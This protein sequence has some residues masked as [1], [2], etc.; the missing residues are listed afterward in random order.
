MTFE[1][2]CPS[3]LSGQLITITAHE[4]TNS[5][6]VVCYTSDEAWYSICNS[7]PHD[8]PAT[9]VHIL[10]SLKVR[11]VHLTLVIG[12]FSSKTRKNL[13]AS[14]QPT[15]PITLGYTLPILYL[16]LVQKP[17]WNS[18]WSEPFRLVCPS[19]SLTIRWQ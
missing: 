16:D 2:T 13:S 3:K 12:D 1:T 7:L 17:R 15:S 10:P 11:R 4:R 9:L 5:G 14:S 8:N 6:K 19:I 18:T